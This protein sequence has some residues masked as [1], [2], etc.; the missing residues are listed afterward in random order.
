MVDAAPA[1]R[2]VLS[3]ATA[4]WPNRNKASD[5]IVS[6]DAHKKQN[7]SSDHDYGNAVDLTHDP[8]NGC[9]AH[10]WVRWLIKQDFP[11]VKYAISNGSIWSA[12]R[13]SEGWRQY[14]GS[15][16]HTKHAHISINANHRN[17]TRSWFPASSRVSNPTE[18][19]DDMTDA[20]RKMLKEVHAMLS[21]LTA[22]RQAD[23]R[24]IDPHKLSLA[25][26]YTLIEK[27]H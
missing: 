21:Q 18:Q 11:E 9:D 12:A 19:E 3:Q 26:I 25:D 6:S 1:C 23:K 16:A 24:D 27:E 5:G 13:R 8:A 22:P 20:D 17:S 10:A 15:N 2:A 7:P 14:T 4:R